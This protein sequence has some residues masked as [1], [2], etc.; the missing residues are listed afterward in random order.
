M[1]DSYWFKHDSNAGRDLKLLE[2]GQIYT[3][4][5]KGIYW[6]VIEVLREQS[7][8]KFDKSKLQV[9]CGMIVCNDYIKFQNWYKDCLR[10]GLFIEDD[11]YFFSKSLMERMKYWESKKKS[12]LKAK[13]KR[14][15][16][17]TEG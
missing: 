6:D 1:K 16:S 11:K 17:E 4:W 13:S 15:R 5:G 7:E 12:G 2:I 14:N 10:I 3:H 9:L 8:Y